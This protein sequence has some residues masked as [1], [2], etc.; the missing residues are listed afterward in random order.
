[1]SSYVCDYNHYDRTEQIVLVPASWLG[2]VHGQHQWAPLCGVCKDEWYD[3]TESGP[4]IKLTD[5]S[6]ETL[7]KIFVKTLDER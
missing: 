1:M 5:A 7:N 3:S 6:P 4:L 2:E